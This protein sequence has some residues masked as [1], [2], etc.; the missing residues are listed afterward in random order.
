LL[1]KQGKTILLTT[2]YMDE[3]QILCDRLVIMDYGKILVNGPPV[4]L[5]RSRVGKEVVEVWGYPA[6]LV[7]HARGEGWSFETDTDRLF[8]YTDASE[9][10]FTEIASRYTTE[11]CTIRPAGLE[12]LFLRLTGRELRE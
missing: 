2:H 4:E 10:V 3:A 6:E 7:E 5:V 1:K 12:D 8:I 11:R 9:Q